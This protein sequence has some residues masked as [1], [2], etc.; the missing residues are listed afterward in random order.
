MYKY[1]IPY[2]YLFKSRLKST[3][4]KISWYLVYPLPLMFISYYSQV[5]LT[6][7]QFAMIFMLSFTAFINVY[8]IGYIVNDTI[9]IYKE[10]NPTIRISEKEGALLSLNWHRI[11]LLRAMVSFILLIIA[12][13]INIQYYFK[14]NFLA[15]T[16]LIIVELF[17]FY[18]H[19]IIRSR[20]NV[21]TYFILSV[22]KYFMF[23]FL[24]ANG[25]SIY[26]YLLIVFFMFPLVRTAEHASKPRYDLQRII[27]LVGDYDIFRIKYYG[28]IL[29][30]VI[31]I[32]HFYRQ[33]FKLTNAMLV[34][35]ITFTYFFIYRVA[36][37]YAVTKGIYRNKLAE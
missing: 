28:S 36:C 20:W 14:L 22:G 26:A 3:P 8:E 24:F 18:L 33:P 12:Y 27:R 35:F 13:L 23:V 9:T 34:A 10:S 32:S 11:A 29:T 17:V 1:Y 31:V 16:C 21:L 4:E 19:N 7:Q 5:V 25:D 6:F 30:I 15:Y 37:L 2:L